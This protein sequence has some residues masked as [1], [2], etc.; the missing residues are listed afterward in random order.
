MSARFCGLSQ[1]TWGKWLGTPWSTSYPEVLLQTTESHRLTQWGAP[2]GNL[3]WTYRLH[4]EMPLPTGRFEPVHPVRGHTECWCLSQRARCH[5]I[6]TAL[7]SDQS[8][9]RKWCTYVSAFI[10]IVSH[11]TLICYC[12][13][14]LCWQ[15]RWKYSEEP[16]TLVSL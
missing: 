9:G 7:S 4:A 8:S 2:G 6:S 15:M 13:L 10:A 16:V 11:P 1:L 5:H 3:H 12:A 14:T